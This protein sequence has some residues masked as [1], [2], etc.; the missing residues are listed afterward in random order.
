[1]CRA[2]KPNVHTRGNA[3]LR[4]TDKTAYDSYI[5]KFNLLY[6]GVITQDNYSDFCKRFLTSTGSA[7]LVKCAFLKSCD[8]AHDEENHAR[9]RKLKV[10]QLSREIAQVPE[11]E[12]YALMAAQEEN[13]AGSDV[14]YLALM[15][16]FSGHPLSVLRGA[17]FKD[18][19]FKKEYGLFV[20]KKRFV[21]P[22]V[23]TPLRRDR[24][25]RYLFA[26]PTGLIPPA[27][28]LSTHIWHAFG[29]TVTDSMLVAASPQRDRM[30][31]LE[32]IH[33]ALDTFAPLIKRDMG[34][35]THVN[36][37]SQ[38]R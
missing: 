13:V 23:L 31:S 4:L 6:S 11:D 16:F 25:Q 38:K 29:Q 33:K 32:K 26:D 37:G 34:A 5:Q 12:L 18:F 21:P 1:M 36:E 7:T 22:P 19:K 30:C 24:M 10:P 20:Y 28:E 35:Q 14:L 27:I 2:G 8:L 3:L 9:A 15:L 17:V